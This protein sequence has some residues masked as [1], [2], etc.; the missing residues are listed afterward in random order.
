MSFYNE[1]LCRE[2]VNL[3]TKVPQ[4]YGGTPRYLI[5]SGFSIVLLIGQEHRLPSDIDPL[6][7]DQIV[8]ESLRRAGYQDAFYPPYRMPSGLKINSDLLRDTSLP[9]FFSYAGR[10]QPTQIVHPAITAVQKARHLLW[11]S[12]P[13]DS[14]DLRALLS[15][16]QRYPSETRDWNNLIT[17]VTAS[18]GALAD[19]IDGVVRQHRAVSV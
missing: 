18:Q 14:V 5:S 17:S 1:H 16:Q 19:Q 13:K 8:G 3:Q 4:F 6:A 11:Q 2:L 12:R 9:L 10:E 15:Y 7:F